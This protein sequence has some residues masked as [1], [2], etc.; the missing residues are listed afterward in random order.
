VHN[1]NVKLMQK[2]WTEILEPLGKAVIEVGEEVFVENLHIKC[3]LS[4]LGKDG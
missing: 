1:L 3:V 2:R 4:L